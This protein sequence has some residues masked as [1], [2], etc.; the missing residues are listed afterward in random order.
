MVLASRLRRRPGL[1]SLGDPR[2]VARMLGR[3]G[4]REVLTG[5]EPYW[6]TVPRGTLALAPDTFD[7]IIEPGGA[8]SEW[9]WR[10]TVV[11]LLAADPDLAQRLEPG[12]DTDVRVRELLARAHPDAETLPGDPLLTGWWGV[13]EEGE[14]RAVVGAQR[15]APGLPPYLVSLGVAPEARGRRLAGAVLA[16]AV[17]DGLAEGAEIGSGVSLAN[18]AANESAIRVYDRHG[19]TLRHAFESV[20]AR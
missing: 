6:A 7:G 5:A 10:W 17:R 13:V 1:L 14:L 20:R 4:V 16:A 18:Y 15:F 9:D 19:F 8:P 12:T 11:S 2:E 3:P